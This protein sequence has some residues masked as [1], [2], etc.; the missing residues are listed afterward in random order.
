[1]D[2]A[3]A[4][5]FAGGTC[6]TL[7]LKTEDF[8]VKTRSWTFMNIVSDIWDVASILLDKELSFAPE[9]PTTTT[10]LKK[11]SSM[12]DVQKQVKYRLLG[13]RLSALQ[14]ELPQARRRL[15]PR[16]P[17]TL[18]GYGKK[19]K[20]TKN[21]A[22]DDNDGDVGGDVGDH[23]DGDHD[24]ADAVDGQSENS[25]VNTD[26][27]DGAH[28]C[29]HRK[30]RMLRQSR[31]SISS[32]AKV[33]LFQCPVCGHEETTRQALYAHMDSTCLKTQE[34]VTID[35]ENVQSMTHEK[36]RV[37]VDVPPQFPSPHQDSSEAATDASI[38]MQCP[39]CTKSLGQSS[40]W[41]N[42]AL[43]VHVDACLGR[44]EKRPRKTIS[45]FFSIL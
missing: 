7:K 18:L 19:M 6:V 20:M 37:C 33:P 43:N 24:H 9:K 15:H 3:R 38:I 17:D 29:R 25:K 10:F 40:R 2:D 44:H 13:L 27:L 11:T 21:A 14:L 39:I 1:M 23:D 45:D 22:A 34:R 36:G 31:L 32:T 28:A 41:D 42:D 35:E 12:H 5:H 26:T 8:V 4:E 16:D 30:T